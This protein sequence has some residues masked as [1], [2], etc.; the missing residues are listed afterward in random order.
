M[1]KSKGFTLAE[2]LAVISVLGL[3]AIITIPTVLNKVKST[4]E[5]LYN[6]QIEMIK[7]GAISYVTNEISSLQA[8]SLFYEAIMNHRSTS[9]NISLNKLQQG[10]FLEENISNPLCDG[11]D[12][13]FSPEETI[14]QIKY[15]GKE[16]Y[17]EILDRDGAVRESCT[18]KIVR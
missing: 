14:V 9:I 12:K 6:N 5:D 17:Y 11:D 15:D 13:Y 8:D 18:E 4:K 7:S 1:K 16:F 10:G 2:L 3:I